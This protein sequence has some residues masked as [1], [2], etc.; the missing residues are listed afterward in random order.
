MVIEKTDLEI[1]KKY[2]IEKVSPYLIILFGSAASGN[3]RSDSDIDIA[4]LSNK[5]ISAYNLFL[6][7]QELAE[8]L[9]RN[10]DIIDLEE[11]TTVFQMQILSKGKVIYCV[12]EK[13]RVHFQILT[14]K[15][16]A[17]LNEERK[18]I[19]DK[20]TRRGSVYAE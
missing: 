3:M 14:Y 17:R 11:A 13:K 12:N 6:M 5:K 10:V 15:K 16:Y 7:S 1:I 4:F 8:L 19:L 18:H 9:G 2:L 20:I